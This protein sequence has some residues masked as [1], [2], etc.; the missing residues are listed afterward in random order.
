MNIACNARGRKTKACLGREGLVY[1][2]LILFGSAALSS[3]CV[4]S[5]ET[6]MV[7]GFKGRT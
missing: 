4:Q 1:L 7:K 6:K 3:E 5:R 2:F